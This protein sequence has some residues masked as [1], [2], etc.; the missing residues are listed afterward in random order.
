[1]NIL[2]QLNA[3][4]A[5]C[6]RAFVVATVVS[7]LPLYGQA[8]TTK[9]PVA[10]QVQQTAVPLAIRD[11][12]VIDVAAGQRLARQTVI[13]ARGRIAHVGPVATTPIPRTAR[14]VDGTG[15]FLIPGL[16][17]MHVHLFWNGS[18]VGTNNAPTYFPMLLANGVTGVRDMWTDLDDLAVVRAWA[19]SVQA[20]T[21]L[22]PRVVASSPII[23]ASPPVWRNSLTVTDSAQAARA[24]DSLANAGVRFVKTYARL[25]PEAF[26]AIAV[27]ARRRGISFGGHV[28]GAVRLLDASNAG[29]RSVEHLDALDAPFKA[30]CARAGDSTRSHYV[31]QFDAAFAHG[32][33]SIFR[34]V[35]ALTDALI[36]SHEPQRCVDA[37]TTLARKGTWVVPTLVQSSRSKIRDSTLTRDVRL[38]YIGPVQRDG[39][40]RTTLFLVGRF[41]P[42]DIA[43]FKREQQ[44]DYALAKTLVQAGVRLLAGTDLG[45][46]YIYAGFSLHDELGQLVDAGLTPLQALQTATINPARYLGATDSLG[47]IAPGMAAD[48]VLLEADPL[49]EISNSRRIVAVIAAGHLI[50]AGGRRGLLEEA[51]RAAQ[52]GPV[53]NSGG[54]RR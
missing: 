50:D 30:A 33:D 45:N 47:T 29:M 1:M 5:G 23:D 52:V 38:M 37:F 7:G 22:A 42:E 25:S 44:A 14:I 18:N 20:G 24:V 13:V 36:A 21:R 15:R 51:A 17:D 11:V 41:R 6:R 16:W 28:P 19:D 26:R 35:A 10:G 31:S 34:L 2:P 9:H 49:R 53:A 12:T 48:L 27:H 46:P 32:R 54:G 8:D 39:W 3:A 40:Q 43:A 4:L